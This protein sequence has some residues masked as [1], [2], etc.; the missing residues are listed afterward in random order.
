[1]NATSSPC[2]DEENLERDVDTAIAACGGD[3]RAAVR[4]LLLANAFLESELAKALATTS[5]GYAR[6]GA[7]IRRN[8]SDAN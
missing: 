8:K 4:A 7:S 6:R 5:A 2:S 3:L 1:M